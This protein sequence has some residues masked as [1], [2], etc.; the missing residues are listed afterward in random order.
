MKE[1]LNDF[2]NSFSCSDIGNSWTDCES[3]NNQVK[4]CVLDG[5]ADLASG[6]NA[7]DTFGTDKGLTSVFGEVGQWAKKPVYAWFRTKA[8]SIAHSTI[9]GRLLAPPPS[10]LDTQFGRPYHPFKSCVAKQSEIDRFKQKPEYSGKPESA[11]KDVMEWCTKRKCAETKGTASDCGLSNPGLINTADGCAQ[12]YNGT[13]C[14]WGTQQN[15][16]NGGISD[17]YYISNN[18]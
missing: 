2:Q 8:W 16:N 6:L 15:T 10:A 5:N 4:C 18:V 3:L 1:Y 14:V 9:C 12:S 17:G 13:R 7:C 11:M